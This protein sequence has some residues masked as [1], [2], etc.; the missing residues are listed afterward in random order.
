VNGTNLINNA[1]KRKQVEKRSPLSVGKKEKLEAL[2]Q[3]LWIPVYLHYAKISGKFSIVTQCQK[4]QGW[5]KL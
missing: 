3:K 4:I 5:L 1:S 2:F